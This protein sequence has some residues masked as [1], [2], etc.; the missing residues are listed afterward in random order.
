MSDR[1]L[2]FEEA[3]A[4]LKST[5]DSRW[6]EIYV[7]D[8][9]KTADP[10]EYYT[11]QYG[12]IRDVTPGPDGSLWIMTDN[13]DGRGQPRDGDVRIMQVRLTELVEG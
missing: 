4:N 8:E 5:P 3:R 9:A 2:S 10:V 1:V 13:T 12:R 6:R 7:D 11:G